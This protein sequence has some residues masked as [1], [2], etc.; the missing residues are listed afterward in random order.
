MAVGTGVGVG[1]IDHRRGLSQRARRRQLHILP[2]MC[3]APVV[4]GEGGGVG[5]ENLIVLGDFNFYYDTPREAKDG[6]A[7]EL[8]CKYNSRTA[9]SASK[10]PKSVCRCP[11]R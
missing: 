8:F 4:L 5:N 10:N 7:I 3:G 9:C 2:A 11:N 6:P 1:D